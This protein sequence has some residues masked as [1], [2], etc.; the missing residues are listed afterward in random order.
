M[1]KMAAI[2]L[3][4]FIQTAF[5]VFLTATAWTWLIPTDFRCT[6][7]ERKNLPC[8]FESIYFFICP[9]IINQFVQFFLS[10]FLLFFLFFS[11]F[12]NIWQFW[13]IHFMNHAETFQRT[14]YISCITF[15]GIYILKSF[16]VFFY[17]SLF[18][19]SFFIPKIIRKIKG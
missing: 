4:V 17:L 3:I 15:I 13:D 7:F 18:I 10:G 16:K 12:A 5:F 19:F 1:A 8:I 14:A 6:P 11:F 2:V 9:V